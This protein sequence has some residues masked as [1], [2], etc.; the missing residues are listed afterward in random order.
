MNSSDFKMDHRLL[1]MHILKTLRYI[2]GIYGIGTT[3][4]MFFT[5]YNKWD[6]FT[7]VIWMPMMIMVA[8]LLA[9]ELYCRRVRRHADY[10]VI[11]SVNL[12]ICTMAISLYDLPVIMYLLIFPILISLF[13]Y[14]KRLTRYSLIQGL[15]TVPALYLISAHL[16]DQLASSDIV[17]I[18]FMLIGTSLIIS[19]LRNYTS[20]LMN[21]LVNITR[22]KQDLQTKNVV[23]EQLNLMDSATELYN[24]RSFHE[25]LDS[26][27]ALQQSYPLTMHLALIDIDNFKQVNDKFGHA[28]G[29]EMIKYVARQIRAQL[30][31]DEFASRYGGEEFAILCVEK[32]TREFIEQL[33]SIRRAIGRKKHPELKGNAISVSIG[34]QRLMP[35]M[36]K[37]KFFEGADT[38][39]YTAKRSGKDQII[40][41]S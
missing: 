9:L 7:N 1:T 31:P 37:E 16:R 32:S 18:V 41:L 27:M 11:T 6:F 5:N 22:E 38:A 17:V 13:Y 19:S 2:I 24:H 34:V 14:N 33:E 10:V 26:M 8:I 3:I 35:G 12:L 36:S 20:S 30:K 39:L 23:M 21:D 40:I 28:A 15:L 25:H 29:D 4:E